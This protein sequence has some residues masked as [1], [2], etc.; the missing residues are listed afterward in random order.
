M[1]M[2]RTQQ[3]FK[4]KFF[5]S[6]EVVLFNFFFFLNRSC[7]KCFTGP[8]LL[9]KFWQT[10]RSPSQLLPCGGR[11]HSQICL[12]SFGFLCHERFLPA[13]RT[14]APCKRRERK[15]AVS[16][17]TGGT[18]WFGDV[19]V[20]PPVISVLRKSSSLSSNRYAPEDDPSV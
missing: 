20:G 6:L 9:I 17:P 15:E 13:G 10:F 3:N 11:R 18:S 1:E 14:A 12:T 5:H 19:D 2:S 8:G 4:S 7:A 16:Q